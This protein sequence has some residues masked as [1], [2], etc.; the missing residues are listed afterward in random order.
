[1]NYINPHFQYN[2]IILFKSKISST[3]A[4]IYIYVSSTAGV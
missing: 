3:M 2:I 1:M 4:K